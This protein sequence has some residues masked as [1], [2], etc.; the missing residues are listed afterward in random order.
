MQ[1]ILVVGARSSRQGTGPFLAAGLAAAGA[2]ICAVV[3]TRAETVQ[4]AQNALMSASDI[5]CEGYTDLHQALAAEQPEAVVLCTPWR[6]HAD[7]LRVVAEAGCHCLVEKPLAW[8]ASEAQIHE[9]LAAFEKRGLLLQMV[10]QW[11]GTLPAFQQLHGGLPARID[12]FAMRLSPI[13][14]GPEMITDSA[15]HF[16]SLLQ[17]L[18]GAGD[19]SSVRLLRKGERSLQLESQY[20]HS[21]GTAGAT[22][23]LETSPQRPRPAWFQVNDL[24]AEREV[25]LPDYR[26][27]FAAGDSR[28]PIPDPMHQV[29]R[30]FLYNLETGAATGGALLRRA[31]Q[32]LLQ[33]AA[34]W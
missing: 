3:G 29:A 18:L 31:H 5:E 33:L 11:P 23:H 6:Y 16:I 15:P 22:L 4:A 7:Q 28:V 13:S 25:E 10:A 26:Q 27:Y 12:R 19:F 1:R 21:T 32:N 30:E 9:L 17:A 14:I 24:R 20:R 8:P 2:R 34:A